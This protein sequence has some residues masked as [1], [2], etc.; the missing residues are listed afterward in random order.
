MPD[1]RIV[2]V[3]ALGVFAGCATKGGAPGGG[4]GNAGT[5]GT[6]GSGGTGGKGDQGDASTAGTGGATDGGLDRP[7]F[8]G[9]APTAQFLAIYDRTLKIRCAPCH[10]TQSPRAGN[11]DLGDATAALAALTRGTTSCATASPRGRVVPGQPDDSYVIKKLLGAPGI[12]GMRMPRGCQDADASADGGVDTVA[13]EPDAPVERDARSDGS[14]VDGRA[15]DAL[16]TEAAG[17]DGPAADAPPDGA[18][19][20]NAQSCL[21]PEAI[22]A[23]RTWIRT[24]AK[25]RALAVHDFARA[26]NWSIE[27]DLQVGTTGAH[28]WFD[29][30][31]TYLVAV[32]PGASR[33]LGKAWIKVNAQSKMYTG[34]PQ[35]TISLA[36][37]ADVYLVVD[38]RWSAAGM[39]PAWLDGWTDSGL[40]VTMYENDTRPALPFSLYVKSA[41]GGDLTV[42]A[43]G[44]NSAYDYFII[45]D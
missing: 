29:Y 5:G 32:D 2:V 18:S 16:E 28:P 15:H 19:T 10:V 11:L 13:P 4:S 25:I 1:L 17:E 31:R 35:A 34:G 14:K 38:D 6:G 40:N 41:P 37:P 3:L 33:L 9:E 7:S 39:V 12:C 27:S 8:P 24:G 43:I 45:V 20:P 44:A 21:A 23:I 36:A 42:P 26:A 22:E 30:P